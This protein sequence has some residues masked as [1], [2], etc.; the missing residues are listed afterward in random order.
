MWRWWCYREGVHPSPLVHGL[1]LSTAGRRHTGEPFV[2]ESVAP[3]RGYSL[4]AC[5]SRSPKSMF[6]PPPSVPAQHL[7]RLSTGTIGEEGLM[8]SLYGLLTYKCDWCASV[9]SVC[10]TRKSAGHVSH[11]RIHACSA[12]KII[13]RDPIVPPHH[14]TLVH[15]MLRRTPAPWLSHRNAYFGL[16]IG[17]QPSCPPGSAC[18]PPAPRP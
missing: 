16:T 18:S 6:M 3:R 1:R 11:M 8:G 13:V 15:V 9:R 17:G 12:H 7:V 14:Q 4:T 5:T 2:P 10:L